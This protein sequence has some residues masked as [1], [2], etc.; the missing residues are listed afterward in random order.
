[1][2]VPVTAEFLHG[3]DTCPEGMIDCFISIA[4]GETVISQL[5]AQRS[6]TMSCVDVLCAEL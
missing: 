5:T 6:C 1:M 4:E 2:A 3:T